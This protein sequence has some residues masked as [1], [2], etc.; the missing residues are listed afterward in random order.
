MK[1]YKFPIRKKVHSQEHY[2]N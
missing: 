2:Y 1:I